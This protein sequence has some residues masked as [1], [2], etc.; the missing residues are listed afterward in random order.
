MVCSRL[1]ASFAV[2]REIPSVAGRFRSQTAISSQA[3]LGHTRARIDGSRALEPDGL[4]D[5]IQQFPDARLAVP[6]VQLGARGNLRAGS[7][8]DGAAARP[9]GTGEIRDERPELGVMRLAP[10]VRHGE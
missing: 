9:E 7:T 2:L 4:T 5:R 3:R 10:A 1:R 6:A 8:A